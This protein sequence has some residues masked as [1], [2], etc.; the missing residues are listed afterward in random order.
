MPQCTNCLRTRYHDKKRI[1]SRHT[2]VIR[3]GAL[4]MPRSSA[5]TDVVAA[6]SPCISV[7]GRTILRGKDFDMTILSSLTN[8]LHPAPPPDEAVRAGLKRISEIIGPLLAMERGFERRL[9]LP[10][11]HA[12]AYCNQLVASFPPVVDVNRQTFGADPLVNALFA[13]ASDIDH[14][15]AQ[16]RPLREYIANP[17]L[18]GIEHFYAL[19]ATRR[20]E[21]QVLGSETSGDLM[22]REVPRSVLYFSD[23]ALAV[24]ASDEETEK[25]QLRSLAF[26]SLLRSFSA[27]VKAVRAEQDTLH[28]EREME[29]VRI[30]VARGHLSIPEE[31]AHTRYLASLDERLRDNAA[32]LM[33]GRLVMALAD[34]LM[35][36]E[37]AM[38]IEPFSARV[39]RGGTLLAPEGALENAAAEGD[40]RFRLIEFAEL[41]SRDRRKHVVLPVRLRRD[42]AMRAI[43]Q[44]QHARERYIII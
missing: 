6:A 19:L 39:D 34:F 14:M 11:Q 26:D 13:S 31:D 9:V 5:A 20:H 4:G 24:F 36:P 16:S 10:V 17:L 25:S 21:K 33:P 41:V 40:G 3:T 8:W 37:E 18:F 2:D 12:L 29:K 30:L 44:A 32:A 23:H 43:T 7:S 22:Q 15:L 42:D 1:P 38:H 27:H 28:R 35:K